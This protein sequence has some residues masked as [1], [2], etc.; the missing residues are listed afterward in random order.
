MFSDMAVFLEL[1]M[2]RLSVL[3][4]TVL[5]AGLLFTSCQTTSSQPEEQE[6]IRP[7]IPVAALF[8][9]TRGEAHYTSFGFEFDVEVTNPNQVVL[10]YESYITNARMSDYIGIFAQENYDFLS[11]LDTSITSEEQGAVVFDFNNGINEEQFKELVMLLATG[12]SSF[13]AY[14]NGFFDSVDNPVYFI[15][16]GSYDIDFKY[17]SPYLTIVDFP[18]VP[19]AD[20]ALAIYMAALESFPE[21]EGTQIFMSSGNRVLYVFPVE[22]SPEKF[23]DI[24]VELS[25][26]A[27]KSASASEITTP[28]AESRPADSS[29]VQEPAAPVSAPVSAPAPAVSEPVSAPAPALDA[30]PETAGKSGMSP[31]LII[32]IVVLAVVVV[33]CV[34]VFT[35][36]LTKGKE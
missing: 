9:E 35:R 8:P 12:D 20:S 10:S 16:I 6:I 17:I 7:M 36:R 19:A 4:L 13:E 18:G 21:I 22:I 34:V 1:R 26:I 31:G 33:T 11:S 14:L 28:V 3:I 32:L 23:A 29:H 30:Q 15:T 5:V 2:K 27:E 24:L 25:N